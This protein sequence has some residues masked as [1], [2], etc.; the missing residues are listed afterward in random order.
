MRVYILKEQSDQGLLCLSFKHI[1]LHISSGSHLYSL[2]FQET[3]NK[4]LTL[5]GTPII[6]QT[7]IS[8]FVAFSKIT[9]KA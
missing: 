2:Y 5:K 6:Q 1:S 8:N 9:N 3:Y 4:E 7:K